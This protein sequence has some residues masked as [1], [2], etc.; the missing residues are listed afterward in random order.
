MKMLLCLHENPLQGQ[1]FKE[2]SPLL[3]KHGFNPILHKR[4]VKGSKLEP[5]LQSISATAKVSGNPPFGI[6][7]YSW[8]AYL[9]LSYLLRFPENVT[10]VVL[11]NPVLSEE[12]PPV[13]EN[14]VWS[15][16]VIRSLLIRLKKKKL[17]SNYLKQLFAPS[18][19]EEEVRKELETYLSQV[20]VWL[21]EAAYKKLMWTQPIKAEKEH[22][23][24]PVKV[25]YGDLDRVSPDSQYLNQLF[26]EENAL[27]VK[28]GGHALPWSH[29][30]LIAEEIIKHFS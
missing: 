6:V 26:G 22:F 7:A 23:K 5:L 20:P 2:I 12:K 13:E 14:L 1:E 28:E 27:V 30:T 17:T 19:P 15:L 18:E 21:G 24:R 9:A 29:S 16:P 10:G 4:P 25:I 8:G 11:I 3:V